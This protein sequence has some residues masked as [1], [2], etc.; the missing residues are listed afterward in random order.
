MRQNSPYV[1][2]L[3]AT[4]LFEAV[5]LEMVRALLQTHPPVAFARG[6]LL[7]AP[8]NEGRQL[9]FVLRGSALVHKIG[10][11]GA[12]V[13]MSRLHPGDAFGMATLFHDAPFPTEITA[14]TAARALFAPRDWVQDAFV[15]EPRFARNFIRLLSARIHFLARRIE[16]LA[17]DDLPARLLRLLEGLAQG[18][19]AFTLPFR[20]AQLASM[21]DTSRAS[22]YRA[23]DVLVA[24]GAVTRDGRRITLPPP[25][26]D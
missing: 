15:A 18:D 25:P 3:S 10:A 22:L 6:E 13:L 4:P 11:D 23:L 16:L 19:T 20:Y 24:R 12:R 5:P 2:L 14:E 8:A 21:L 7:Y 26:S 1:P 17:G 9:A